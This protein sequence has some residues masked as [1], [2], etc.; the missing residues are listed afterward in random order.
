MR[1]ELAAAPA[2]AAYLAG[3]TRSPITCFI[4]GAPHEPR[5]AINFSVVDTQFVR[6]IGV[7]SVSQ[8]STHVG[9]GVGCV[10][11]DRGVIV[12][13]FPQRAE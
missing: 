2:L 7:E 11:Y 8:A 12:E 3:F 1:A 13:W 4:A 9:E 10:C 6:T 5:R